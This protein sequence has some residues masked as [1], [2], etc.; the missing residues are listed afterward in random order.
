[1]NI[2]YERESKYSFE[3]SIEKVK[4]L[5]KERSFG[6]LWQLNF[7]DKLAEHELTLDGNFM[8]LEVC[9]PKQAQ[10]VLSR[11]IDVGYFLPCKMAIYEK[12]DAVYVGMPRPEKLIG[13]IGHEDLF[14]VGAQV[15]AVLKEVIDEIA[16]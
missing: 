11:H 12:D 9:N 8:V 10:K 13:M 1:M 14:E 2:I 4:T 7:K 15:E 6:V 3:E 5:L 16:A